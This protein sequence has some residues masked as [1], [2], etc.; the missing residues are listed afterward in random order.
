MSILAS[1]ICIAMGLQ[2]ERSLY[3]PTPLPNG[4]FDTG[5]SDRPTNAPLPHKRFDIGESDRT[6]NARPCLVSGSW[7]R[8][9]DRGNVTK[10]YKSVVEKLTFSHRRGDGTEVTVGWKL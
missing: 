10:L 6:A 1:K 2:P 7:G 5:E 8:L 9:G 4:R 3:K